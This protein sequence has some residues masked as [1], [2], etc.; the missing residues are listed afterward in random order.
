[1]SSTPLTPQTSAQT[2]DASINHTAP[3]GFPQEATGE[4]LATSSSGEDDSCST[5]STAS[6]HSLNTPCRVHAAMDREDFPSYLLC[7]FLM[8]EPP[9]HAV[10]FD[11]PYSNRYVSRQVFEESY[12]YR[13]IATTGV[14]GAFRIIRHPLTG[15][16]TRQNNEIN[17]VTRVCH[18]IQ[19]RINEERQ[20]RGLITVEDNPICPEDH[21]LMQQTIQSVNQQ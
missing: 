3:F 4:S 7:P 11:I 14:G 19:E 18:E 17:Y 5:R 20:R 6:S 10:T 9:I 15:A 2:Q 8:G 12:L 21:E 13:H 16:K 1:M